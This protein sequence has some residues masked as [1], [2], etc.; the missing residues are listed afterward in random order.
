M[1]SDREAGILEHGFTA[2]PR[3]VDGKLLK[4]AKNVK[5]PVSLSTKDIEF[6]A[7]PL[8]QKVQ[9]YA[10]AHLN[11]QTF[12]HSMRVYYYGRVILRT[13]FP[14]WTVSPS[15]YALACLLHDIG[16]TAPN[17]RA[18]LL[19]F[20]FHGAFVASSLLASL[21]APQAQNDAVVEA[22]IRHQD[23]GTAGTITTLGQVL[24]LATIFDNMGGH[25]GLVHAE[26]IKDV[27]AKWPRNGWS[28]C[29]AQTIR[30]ENTLKPWAHTTAL[31]EEDFPEGVL[32]N[33]LMEPYD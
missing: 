4:G 28:K 25:A 16:T 10:R 8:V 2:V 31:G 24:Q 15:T 1:S 27:V 17:L 30:T 23:I 5:D 13:Q 14:H 12:H 6:P 21:A 19:S 32:G 22:I 11:E 7:E 26:T 29:F 3:D 9:D 20:E 18:T 33:K